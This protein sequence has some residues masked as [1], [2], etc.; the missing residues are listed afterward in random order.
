MNKTSKIIITILLF[1]LIAMSY[2][3]WNL[4]RGLDIYME[5]LNRL[6]LELQDLK[7]NIANLFNKPVEI[8]NNIYVKEEMINNANTTTTTE[9]YRKDNLI[10][11]HIENDDTTENQDIILN[12]ET[13]KIIRIDNFSKNIQ[14]TEIS[15]DRTPLDDIFISFNLEDYKYF[16]QENINEKNCYK[17]SLSRNLNDLTYFYVGTDDNLLYQME[18]GQYFED[19]FNLYYKHTYSYSFDTVTD[20][21]ILKFD[22]NNYPDYTFHN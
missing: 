22:E 16:G 18:E 12:L 17:F 21:D 8:P 13:K 3:C 1:A 11:Q 6:N 20:E 5:E 7:G 4:N 9:T 15:E 2:Y 14:T 19:K 10:Y